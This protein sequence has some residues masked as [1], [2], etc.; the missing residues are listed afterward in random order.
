M[1]ER[2]VAS[3]IAL[4]V[5]LILTCIIVT[6]VYKYDS[7]LFFVFVFFFRNIDIQF[8]VICRIRIIYYLIN[9]KN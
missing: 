8:R 4:A 1:N 3:K 7:V 2:K 9:S 6:F 5:L